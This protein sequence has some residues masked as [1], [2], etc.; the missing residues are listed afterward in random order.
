MKYLLDTENPDQ[1]YET[2]IGATNR[3]VKLHKGLVQTVQEQLYLDR[4]GGP[5]GNLW[6]SDDFLASLDW[7]AAE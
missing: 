4:R 5:L 6:D 7:Q 3:G 2:I 1:V